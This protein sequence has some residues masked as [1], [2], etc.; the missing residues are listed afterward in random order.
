[1]DGH[2]RIWC[3]LQTLK[4]LGVLGVLA[5]LSGSG[6]G[7]EVENAA[8]FSD[9]LKLQAEPSGDCNRREVS[10]LF[11]STTCLISHT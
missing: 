6:W 1:M 4:L 5:V 10:E 2:E 3:L 7:G 8:T 9:D 11:F